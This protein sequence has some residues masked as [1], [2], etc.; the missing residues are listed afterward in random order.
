MLM[1]FNLLGGF[2]YTESFGNAYKMRI[3]TL[4]KP[5]MSEN[6]REA[7]LLEMHTGTMSIRYSKNELGATYESLLQSN[8]RWQRLFA[9]TRLG[10]SQPCGTRIEPAL[11]MC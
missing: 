5:M 6:M 10:L 4:T 9:P 2:V 8:L 3:P 1:L 7:R 11:R